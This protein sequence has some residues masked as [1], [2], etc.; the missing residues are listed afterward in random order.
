MGDEKLMELVR[1]MTAEVRDHD[2]W[3]RCPICDGACIVNDA[4]G[5]A[6]QCPDCDGEGWIAI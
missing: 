1:D 2:Y 4:A 5:T 3:D 6:I